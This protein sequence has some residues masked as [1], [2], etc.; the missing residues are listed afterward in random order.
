[1]APVAGAEYVTEEVG[2]CV[3][4][5]KAGVDGDNKDEADDEWLVDAAE[6]EESGK[7]CVACG[8]VDDPYMGKSGGT[9]HWREGLTGGVEKADEPK[10]K[11]RR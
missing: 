6:G 11:I 2:A 7:E 5:C 10:K 3:L 8:A 9:G 1:M 4:G